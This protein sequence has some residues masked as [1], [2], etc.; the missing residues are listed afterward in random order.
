MHRKHI[1]FIARSLSK[2]LTKQFLAYETMNG[3]DEV[4]CI[5]GW[6]LGYF[7][8][9]QHIN[10][11][12]KDIEAAF[13][14]SRSTTTGILKLMEQKGYI[15]RISVEK[16]ARLKKIILTDKGCSTHLSIISD[17]T[18]L[19]NSVIRDIS[20]NDLQIFYRVIQQMEKNID[21]N[22]KLKFNN[23]KKEAE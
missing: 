23:I 15:Q 7:Y 9:H 14:M 2:K 11:Y 17:I 18:L 21:E 20:N 4:T 16:D 5:N 22:L 12:Q 6:I 8:D 10:I 1:G 3:M 19:D 13:E